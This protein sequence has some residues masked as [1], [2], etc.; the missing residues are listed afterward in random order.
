M[1]SNACRS[2]PAY[3]AML[4]CWGTHRCQETRPSP[5]GPCAATTLAEVEAVSALSSDK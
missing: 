5:A 2:N 3:T 4:S 1:I